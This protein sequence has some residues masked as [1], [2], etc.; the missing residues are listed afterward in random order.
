MSAGLDPLV[1]PA[2]RL[3]SVLHIQVTRT[4]PST[5]SPPPLHLALRAGQ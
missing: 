5:P 3:D 2:R 4:Y 1:S